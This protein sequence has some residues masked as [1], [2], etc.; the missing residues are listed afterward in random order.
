MSGVPKGEARP[1]TVYWIDH[2]V[3]CTNDPERWRAF[4]TRVLGTGAT[5]GSG[6]P[7][8]IGY[9]LGGSGARIG[10]FI[11]GYP[12]PPTHGLGRGLPRYGFY[13][14]PADIDMHLRRLDANGAPHSKP[15]RTSA[16]GDAGTSIY[17][18]DPDGNQFEFWA[19]DEFPEG[20]MADCSPERVGRISH[21]VF[22]S[23][24]LARTAA[25]FERYCALE[26][27]KQSVAAA[28]SL[29]LRLAGGARLVFHKVDEL[30]GR[31]EG[32]GLPDAHTALLVRREDYF[33]NYQRMWA[34]LPEWDFDAKVN[35]GKPVD[36]PGALTPRTVKHGSPAGKKFHQLTGRGDDWLDWDSNMFHFYG[37]TPIGDSMAAY[38]AYALDYY[39]DEWMRTQ[40][41]PLAAVVSGG[42][43][44]ASVMPRK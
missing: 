5:E 8:S 6:V 16:D 1:G 4:H 11:T 22:E 17:W 10:G 39:V 14:S 42:G 35:M 37:G 3:V 15:I 26:P 25:L 28:D 21:A 43:E 27:C 41:I 30:Q 20:A 32:C 38:D 29:V 13:V 9:F 23:R 36:N 2:A 44:P 18:Q 40:D 7:P 24:D 19:P 12:L 31:T 33:P 34:E